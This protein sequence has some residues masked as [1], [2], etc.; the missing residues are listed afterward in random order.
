VH[1]FEFIVF[2]DFFAN[3]I[4][5]IFSLDK[6]VTVVLGSAVENQQDAFSGKLGQPQ[7]N[8]ASRQ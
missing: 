7:K 1:G 3:F 2:E 5:E 4:P 8:P 6:I